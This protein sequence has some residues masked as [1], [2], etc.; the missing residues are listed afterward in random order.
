MISNL[1]FP[2]SN[3]WGISMQNAFCDS[4]L[5][6]FKKFEPNGFQFSTILTNINNFFFFFWLDLLPIILCAKHQL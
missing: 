5:V 1:I 3:S 2:D 6:V 4:N